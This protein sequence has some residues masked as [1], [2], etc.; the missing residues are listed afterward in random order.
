M[1]D[2]ACIVGIG[3]TKYVRKPGSGLTELQ[4]HLQAT[5]RALEDAGLTGRQIDG[6][7]PSPYVA[8]AELL[9]ANLGAATL[10]F[11]TT[12]HM[13]GASPCA[14]LV[15]ENFAGPTVV[16]VGSQTT[17]SLEFAGGLIYRYAQNPGGRRA[18]RRAKRP[19]WCGHW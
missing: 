16:V 13:G 12:V 15:P 8:T 7:I 11:A 6:I 9:A 5:A 18:L 1:K 17:E 3:E 19:E 4:L 14:A 2:R 10:R